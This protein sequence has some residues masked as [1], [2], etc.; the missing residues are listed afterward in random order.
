MKNGIYTLVIALFMLSSCGA[1]TAES[2][3][4]KWCEMNAK[5]HS[6]T[7]AEEKD[8]AKDEREK[9]EDEIEQKY[10]HDHEMMKKI[11]AITKECDQ[12]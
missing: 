7:S 8:K 12:H 2:I 3:S 1:E 11:S 6:A 4:K 9:Y 10:G 5:V